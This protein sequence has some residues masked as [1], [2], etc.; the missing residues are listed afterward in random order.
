MREQ[1]MKHRSAF[2]TLFRKNSPTAQR[3]SGDTS[4]CDSTP[5][6]SPYGAT[7]HSLQVLCLQSLRGVL[8]TGSGHSSTI[9]IYAVKEN[10]ETCLL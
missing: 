10:F 5:T 3:G 1:I 8:D 9:F 7:V 4:P 6:F 2:H